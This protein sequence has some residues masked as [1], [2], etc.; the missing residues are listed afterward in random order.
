MHLEGLTEGPGRY[1]MKI[2]TGHWMMALFIVWESKSLLIKIL[3]VFLITHTSPSQSLDTPSFCSHSHHL[4]F[5]SSQASSHCWKMHGVGTK[6]SELH[7]LLMRSMGQGSKTP[8]HPDAARSQEVRNEVMCLW[9]CDEMSSRKG[10]ELNWPWG[11]AWGW[12]EE[13]SGLAHLWKS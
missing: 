7:R 6:G 5:L 12:G 8:G 4:L 10:Q 1:P 11:Q 13:N 2:L 3:S 9:A